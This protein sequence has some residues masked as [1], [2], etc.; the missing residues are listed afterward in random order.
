VL[1]SKNCSL[2][3]CKKIEKKA[4]FIIIGL[5]CMALALPL[6]LQDSIEIAISNNRTLHSA[7]LDVTVAKAKLAE[8]KTM[9]LPSLKAFSSYTRL[10]KPPSMMGRTLGDDD[11]YDI[12]TTLQQ[13][14][15]TG[16][17][18][19]FAIK[20]AQGSLNAAEHNYQKI[21]NE[22]ILQV[23]ERY[24]GLLAAEKFYKVAYEA[25]KQVG[26]HLLNVKNFYDLG[27]ANK[28]DLLRVEV[29][30]ATVKQKL[31]K[32]ENGLCL[33]RAAFNSTLGRDLDT[34]VELIDIEKVK[35][36]DIDLVECEKGAIANRPELMSL[37]ENL[38]MANSAISLAKSDY[39]PNIALF[40][41]YDYKK[42]QQLPIE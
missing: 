10:D 17:K 3:D 36:Q 13:P 7:S 25:V 12:K 39:Y 33:A 38:K 8:A 20:M 23:K 42:G 11:I 32:A 15:F 28:V 27:M 37:K 29:E 6:S 40:A 35:F 30:L 14:V 19:T 16:G 18:I 24:F 1:Y 4:Y 31:I 22:L 5:P 34:P 2:W 9:Y 26:A 41:N 21:K